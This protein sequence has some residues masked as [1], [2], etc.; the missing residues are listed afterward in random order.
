MKS[1]LSLPAGQGEYGSD[2]Y[3][4]IRGVRRLFHALSNVAE[5]AHR[6]L[7]VTPSQRAVIE[8]LA[9]G[10]AATV[11]QLARIKG[12]SR[13]H[14][15]VLVNGLLEAGLV[16][17]KENPAHRVSALVALTPAGQ[18][19]F[20]EIRRRERRVLARI[21]RHFKG[22]DLASVAGTLQEL[23]DWIEAME[24]KS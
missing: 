6:D 22:H 23:A 10:R 7:G 12:V 20:E 13:Q 8:D 17:L 16:E 5:E 21:R 3:W 18:S 11:P 19:R 9:D 1:N 2:L 14:I 15:Q 4:V 24:V